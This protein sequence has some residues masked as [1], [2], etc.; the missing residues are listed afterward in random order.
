MR[1]IQF[2]YSIIFLSILSS[3]I[4]QTKRI[5]FQSPQLYPEGT[6][7]NAAKKV[8]YVSSA[9]TAA[10]GAVTPNGNYTVIYND[11]SLKSTYGMKVDEAKQVLWVCAGDANYSK[12]STPATHKKMIRLVGIDL[13]NNKAIANIDLSNLYS[14]NH[15]AND[16]TFDNAGNKYITD[17]YSP[18]IYKVDANNNARIFTQNELFKSNDI[19]LNGIA[20]S[21]NGYLITVNNSTG[22]LLKV[23][24][25]NPANVTVIKIDRFFVG[26]DGLLFDDAGNLYVVQ[27]KSVNK[28]FKLTSSNNWQSAM[29]VA[30]TATVD[31]F[32]NPSTST[33]SNGELFLMNS[34]LNELS[35]PTAKPSNEFSLQ[36]AV[37]KE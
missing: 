10:I 12:Y 36:L 14:G 5:T 15:F 37:F 31:R 35:D 20:C 27:N 32:Q 8:F 2:L 19:G 30:S 28:A 3:S 16:I 34:K 29:V 18:V 7:Y 33:F 26:G 24:M 1:F 21:K 9:T 11:T 6:A 23:D 13:K 17:S 4:A 22:A 25:N